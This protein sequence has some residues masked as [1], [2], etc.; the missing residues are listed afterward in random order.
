MDHQLPVLFYMLLSKYVSCIVNRGVFDI[1]EAK[2]ADPVYYDIK[3]CGADALL[4]DGRIKIA[5][6]YTEAQASC[7]GLIYICLNKCFYSCINT[8][9]RHLSLSGCNLDTLWLDV[10]SARGALYLQ[11]QSIRHPHQAHSSLIVY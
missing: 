7:G 5:S 10:N 3:Y 11:V 9:C 4:K 2:I 8:A 1:P 6:V